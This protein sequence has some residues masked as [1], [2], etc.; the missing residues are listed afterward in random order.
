MQ[1]VQETW[2]LSLG[3]EDILE[4]E[5]ATHSSVVC[6]EN[7]MDRGT[8]QVTVHVVTQSQARWKQ[9]SMHACHSELPSLNVKGPGM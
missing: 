1:A 2:V 8:W 3:W 6:L 7:P 4:E 9:L 5:M